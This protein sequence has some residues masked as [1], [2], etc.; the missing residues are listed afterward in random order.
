MVQPL[1]ELCERVATGQRVSQGAPQNYRENLTLLAAISLRDLS[2]P[3]TVD[4]S[5]SGDVFRVYV[6]EVLRP[7]LQPGEMALM[8]NLKGH[9]V[10]G[11]AELIEARGARLQY[12]PPYSQDLNPIEKRWSKIKTAS[13]QIKA[14]TREALEPA[15]KQALVCVAEA[16]ARAWFAHCGYAV[17]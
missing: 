7:T 13:R 15:L 16:D 9:E 1:S 5:I 6:A 4:S 11:I 17:H 12:L 3:M 14:P 10:A 8:D 2:V